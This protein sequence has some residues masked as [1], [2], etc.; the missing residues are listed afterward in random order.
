[1]T[2]LQAFLSK[3]LFTL[4]SDIQE[5][6]DY[7]ETCLSKI[8]KYK[9]PAGYYNWDHY[10]K[11][12][13][14]IGSEY[15]SQVSF[16]QKDYQSGII[17]EICRQTLFADAPARYIS[18]ELCKAFMQTPTPILSKDILGVLPYVHIFLP[19][20]FVFDKDNEEVIA[21][22]IKAGQIHPALTDTER[23]IQEQFI[24]ST[25]NRII[26]KQLEGANGIEIATVSESGSYFWVDYVDEG[27]K[28]WYDENVRYRKDSELV[29]TSKEIDL[30]A[31][32]AINS[33]LVHLYESELIT[34]DKA[35][36]VTKGLGFTKN[37]SKQ[38]LPAT[39]I[40]KNFRYQRQ[41]SPGKSSEKITSSI[42]AHWRRGH[43]HTVLRGP[44]RS[45]RSVQW[46][47]PIYVRGAD[48]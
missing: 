45:E 42:R 23:Q 1:M 41:Q 16:A 43:W 6:S 46:Y 15:M 39:W 13:S 21:L 44:K 38:P 33:L 18:K 8:K 12:I 40:G 4:L 20:N 5:E 26:P 34:V 25:G 24:G 11:M 19:R 47:R 36:S 37:E 10:L 14:L 28:S 3:P 29:D 9:S 48:Q 35:A 17:G 31:R 32:I 7:K 27:A 2:E 30:I 22:V